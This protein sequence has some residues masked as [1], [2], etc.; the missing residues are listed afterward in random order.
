MLKTLAIAATLVLANAAPVLADAPAPVAAEKK[1]AYSTAE[2]TLGV[3]LEDP[4]AKAITDAFAAFGIQTRQQLDLAARQAEENFR[5]VTSSGQATAVGLTAAFAQY[6]RAQL[7]AGRPVIA[8]TEAQR[9]VLEQVRAEYERKG[10]AAENAAAR[11]IAANRA[12]ADSLSQLGEAA[13]RARMEKESLA[14][15]ANRVTNL[16]DV[17]A[18]AASIDGRGAVG[19]GADGIER[20]A[21]IEQQIRQA[22]RA[23]RLASDAL[24]DTRIES[25]ADIAAARRQLRDAQGLAA[26]LGGVTGSQAVE[27]R[28]LS[29]ELERGAAA[30]ERAVARFEREAVNNGGARTVNPGTT[31]GRD[32]IV[33]NPGGT[34]SP[35]QPAPLPTPQPI[36]TIRVEL[37]LGGQVIPGLFTQNDAQRL[38]DLLE[39]SQLNA[40]GGG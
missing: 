14:N 30:L 13:R 36:Q 19:F 34:A 38:V 29:E 5:R 39:R 24:G 23:G 27:A 25:P 3:L 15:A 7:E 31:L 12:E 10:N 16:K 9:L 18:A 20:L 33:F 1:Q 40:Q 17:S 11:A 37:V 21:E 26:R 2:T 35:Q 6:A 32:Q 4:A 22:I 8:S 28:T